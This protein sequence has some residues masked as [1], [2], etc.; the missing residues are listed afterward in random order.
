MIISNLFT[1]ED[2]E[3]IYIINEQIQQI[4]YLT[5]RII[6]VAIFDALEPFITIL[7]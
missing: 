6:S 7:N 2:L 3:L 4:Y 5:F 1:D